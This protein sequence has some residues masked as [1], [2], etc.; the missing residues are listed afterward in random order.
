MVWQHEDRSDGCHREP[1]LEAFERYD[2]RKGRKN[3]YQER[4]Q[5]GRKVR[6]ETLLASAHTKSACLE[7][8]D[9]E[10]HSGD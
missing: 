3:C 4:A 2:N 7:S 9:A 1:S 10:Y 8:N 5:C 6:S